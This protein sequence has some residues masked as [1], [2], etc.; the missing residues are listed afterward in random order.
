[1][2]K[3]EKNFFDLAIKDLELNNDEI[4]MIGD[5]ITSDIEGSLNACL[6]TVQVKTGKFQKKDLDYA[7]QPH[8]RIESITDL[9]KLLGI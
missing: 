8:N 4:L 5:D 3:P 6:K 9:P 1:M 2:V 7:V